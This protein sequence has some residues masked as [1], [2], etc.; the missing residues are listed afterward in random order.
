MATE[1]PVELHGQNN[2]G[3]VISYT[4]ADGTGIPINTIL[5]LSDDRTAA[6][7]SASGDIFAGIASSEKVA[8]DGETNIGAYTK[9]V[10]LLEI[11]S[12]STGVSAGDNVVIAGA[13]V[14]DADNTATQQGL[15]VGTA[16]ED[17]TAGDK[18]EVRINK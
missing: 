6:A 15:I 13:N 4:C 1:D 8:D 10:F 9:G 18:I 2:A 14:I 3:E 7:S 16:L 12:E 5:K 11:D 17:G